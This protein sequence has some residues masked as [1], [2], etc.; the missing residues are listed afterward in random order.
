MLKFHP[1]QISQVIINLIKNAEDSL[2]DEKDENE[3]WV[4][5]FLK[6]FIRKFKSM[7]VT[8]DLRFLKKFR[9]NCFYLFTT[10]GVGKATGLGLSISREIKKG[11][12]RSLFNFNYF[13][14]STESFLAF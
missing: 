8:G 2:Q 1:V 3:R 14:F 6:Q 5:F 4:N 12:L 7:S 10:K 11:P 13:V 9:T